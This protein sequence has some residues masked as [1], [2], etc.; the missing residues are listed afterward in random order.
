MPQRFSTPR[1]SEA[2]AASRSIPNTSMR[3]ETLGTRP[4]MVRVSTD[5]PAPDGP[6]KPKISP[7]LTSR[8]SPSRI[9]VDPNCTVMSRTR[10][11]ASSISRARSLTGVMSHPD[12]SEEDREHAVHHDDEEDALHH[13]RRGVLTERF[14]AAL[15]REPLDA[16]DDADHGGHHRRLDD[17][18]D[19][20]IDRDRVA[21]PQQ[22]GFGIDPAIEPCHQATAIERRH[23]AE[24]R[25]D[26]HRDD[27]RQHPRQDQHF[28]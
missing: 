27:Q 17:A 23:R 16:G 15:D 3:P 25:Q 8:L 18:D 4:M 7:R 26:R 28:D 13:R 22:E 1:R 14:R 21:Q 24:K 11:M 10:M 6:T 19:E 2:F 9:R 12:R 20:V 5:L